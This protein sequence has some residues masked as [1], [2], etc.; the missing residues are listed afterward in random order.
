MGIVATVVP[1][2]VPAG[3]ALD[4]DFIAPEGVGLASILC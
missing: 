2:I 3:T 1:R 4:N